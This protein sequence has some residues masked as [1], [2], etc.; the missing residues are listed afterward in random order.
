[1][2]LMSFKYL[3]MR[4]EASCFTAQGG[5]FDKMLWKF[6]YVLYEFES[7]N[8]N[9]VIQGQLVLVPEMLFFFIFINA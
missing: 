8:N 5:H 3:N 4:K 7:G 6:K 9:P 1:L 2:A